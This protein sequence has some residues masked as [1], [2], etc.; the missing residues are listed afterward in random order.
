MTYPEAKAASR[1]SL[2][3]KRHSRARAGSEARRPSKSPGTARRTRLSDAPGAYSGSVA[4]APG[5]SGAERPGDE[6]A[7]AWQAPVEAFSEM[8]PVHVPQVFARVGAETLE[9]QPRVRGPQWIDGPHDLLETGL[10]SDDG[11][12]PF[13]GEPDTAAVS[14]LHRH[15]VGDKARPAVHVTAPTRYEAHQPFPIESP[16]Y[17]P[18]GFVYGDEDA[19]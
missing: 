4:S 1:L 7:I 3:R 18:A 13:Q 17:F 2:S 5:A 16:E 11:L 12:E 8:L 6:Q 10:E 15:Q 9:V 19:G 14:S